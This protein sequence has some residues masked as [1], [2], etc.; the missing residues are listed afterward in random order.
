MRLFIGDR[1]LSNEILINASDSKQLV[2][3]IL[4]RQRQRNHLRLE[5]IAKQLGAK[6][7]NEYAQVVS[8]RILS[9]FEQLSAYALFV[10]NSCFERI[11]IG[12]LQTN[13]RL[14]V[15]MKE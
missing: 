9:S 1:K 10:R 14:I 7:L 11:E 4:R 8:K 2:A 3:I 5:D 6:S 15:P 13:K 12:I